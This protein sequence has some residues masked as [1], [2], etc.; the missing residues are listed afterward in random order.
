[1]YCYKQP[2]YNI[3]LPPPTGQLG[4]GTLQLLLVDK[5]RREKHN[6]SEYRELMIQ[7]Y[8]P[9]D[10]NDYA[11]KFVPYLKRSIEYIKKNLGALKE[12]P[13]TQLDY[14][15]RVTTHCVPN[16]PALANQL[17]FPILIFSPG[18]GAPQET[19]T[20]LL[21]E[22]ASQGYVVFGINH[23]YVT[24]PTIFPDGRVIEQAEFSGPNA[25]EKKNEEFNT[26]FKDIEFFIGE[27]KLINE[28]NPI[29]LNKLYLEEI[30]IFGHSF[31][32][33]VAIEICRK[34]ARIK[35]GVDLDGKLVPQTSLNGFNKPFMFILAGREELQDQKR[36]ELL[37]KNIMQDSFLVI[38]KGADH[39]TFTDLNYILQPWMAQSILNPLKGIEI[40]RL[41]LVSFFNKYLKKSSTSTLEDIRLNYRE[42]VIQKN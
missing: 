8:Y 11:Q 14:I 31:G 38:V 17:H 33:R 34:D 30:G 27:L 29:L 6:P 22:L 25:Q 3:Q 24:N 35:A 41:L 2:F 39:G 36:I 21:E 40:V 26:W 42:V 16:A 1:M 15:D 20:T 23:P 13:L 37:Q 19:Y 18:F 4:I 5:L 9:T 32:G 7:V 12:I 28:T 10:K